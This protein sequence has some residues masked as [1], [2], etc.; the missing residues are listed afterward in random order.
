METELSLCPCGGRAQTIYDGEMW[1]CLC[2]RCC[3]SSAS[4][5][6][7]MA[8]R[9]WEL[10][11]TSLRARRDNVASDSTPDPYEQPIGELSQAAAL[12]PATSPLPSLADVRCIWC[13]SPVEFDRLDDLGVASRWQV[14]CTTCEGS[15]PA[16]P[17]PEDA[18]RAF[19][20]P[21]RGER[22]VIK[23]LTAELETLRAEVESARRFVSAAVE[24]VGRLTIEGELARRDADRF[25]VEARDL[26]RWKDLGLSA[27]NY[28]ELAPS[29]EEFEAR[30]PEVVDRLIGAIRILTGEDWPRLAEGEDA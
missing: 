4:A 26:Y 17:T 1:L 6:R 16:E 25:E 22:S 29:R 28:A 10:G 30:A 14:D 23:R 9:L 19:T 2:G 13:A 24:R 8:R 12:T 27:R 18:V 5:Q 11:V 21:A 20:S 15:G 7:M 3:R